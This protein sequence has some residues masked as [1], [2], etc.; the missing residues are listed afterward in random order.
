MEVILFRMSNVR[1]WGTS[2]RRQLRV[3]LVPRKESGLERAIG[4]QLHSIS[5]CVI[6]IFYKEDLL[7]SLKKQKYVSTHT[8]AKA[9]GEV[10]IIGGHSID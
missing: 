9:S 10:W 2:R 1:F 3:G 5:S 7:I 4:A 8:I 6:C